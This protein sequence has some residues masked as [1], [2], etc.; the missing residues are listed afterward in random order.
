M[1][2]TCK[3][4]EMYIQNARAQ[5]QHRRQTLLHTLHTRLAT[6][7]AQLETLAARITAASPQNALDRGFALVSTADGKLARDASALHPGDELRIR[8][9]RG[10]TTAIVR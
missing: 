1:E 2:C 7:R 3:F 10:E 6:L 8:L 9:A 5:L 4:R